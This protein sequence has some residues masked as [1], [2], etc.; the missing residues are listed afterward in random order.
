MNVNFD[1]EY[2][3][4]CTQLQTAIDTT[5]KRIQEKKS[6][7]EKL[8]NIINSAKNTSNGL[9]EFPKKLDAIFQKKTP[10]LV[11][12]FYDFKDSIIF[13]ANYL[14]ELNEELKKT[15]ELNSIT[16]KINTFVIFFK[17]LHASFVEI[18]KKNCD[19][20]KKEHSYKKV[21][22]DLFPDG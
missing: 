10:D 17:N 12:G 5:K 9:Q 3:K 16:Q 1:S 21:Y 15:S 22:V 20:S 13:C 11:Q 2:S 18:S 6:P 4:I 7:D 14:N 8:L 19:L